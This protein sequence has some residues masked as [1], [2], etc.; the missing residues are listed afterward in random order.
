MCFPPPQFV[1]LVQ[2][3]LRPMIEGVIVNSKQG[4]NWDFGG[5]ETLKLHSHWQ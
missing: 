4:L 1:A 3:P 5:C 2:T